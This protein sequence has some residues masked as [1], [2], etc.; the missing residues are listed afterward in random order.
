MKILSKIVF[1][2]IVALIAISSPSGAQET[3]FKNIEPQIIKFSDYIRFNFK[4]DDYVFFE[5]VIDGNMLIIDFEK[6]NNL[7]FSSLIGK[8]DLLQSF[9]VSPDNKS[10][11]IRLGSNGVKLRKFFGDDF[12][13]G[14]DIFLDKDVTT[15]KRRTIIM[16]DVPSD[17]ELN[18]I[19][20]E[21]ESSVI[22]SNI[23]TYPL[24]FIGPPRIGNYK[25]HFI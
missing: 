14:I 11:I 22:N 24:E 10:M 8:T 2:Y 7:D 23:I 20:N 25:R 12:T 17:A 5:P 19:N 4:S 18:N 6:P 15:S 9:G 3:D 1:A 13:T 16:S 21:I